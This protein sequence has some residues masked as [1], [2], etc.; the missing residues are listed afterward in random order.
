MK[1]YNAYSESREDEFKIFDDK[2]YYV[3]KTRR[4]PHDKNYYLIGNGIVNMVNELGIQISDEL[5]DNL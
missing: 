4:Y 1:L 3:I 2:R 5:M